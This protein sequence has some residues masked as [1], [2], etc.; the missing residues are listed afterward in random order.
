MR[1]VKDQGYTGH[2]EQT[3]KKKAKTLGA[4]LKLLA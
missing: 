3:M 2:A 4:R 1:N